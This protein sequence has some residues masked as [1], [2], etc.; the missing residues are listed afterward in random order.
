[1]T[2]PI[3][4][5]ELR[6][7][8]RTAFAAASRAGRS[9]AEQQADAA[10]HDRHEERRCQDDAGERQHAAGQRDEHAVCAILLEDAES[11]NTARPSSR[12]KASSAAPSTISRTA[13]T[14]RPRLRA[15]HRAADAPAAAPSAWTGVTVSTRRL[16][17][18]DASQVVSTTTTSGAIST[19]VI[20]GYSRSGSTRSATNTRTAASASVAAIAPPSSDRS[21][22]RRVPRLR[23]SDAA[24]ARSSRSAAG[25]R[26]CACDR[27]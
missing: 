8:L 2:R 18:Q 26:S 9:A 11:A 21:A 27:R 25:A 19:G 23:P 4:V 5:R 14:V 22:R 20:T 10:Q 7:G 16:P 6:S 24:P 1:M 12:P 3:V 17:I 13:T 15:Q